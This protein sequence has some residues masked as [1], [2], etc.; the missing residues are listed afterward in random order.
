M[1]ILKANYRHNRS[2]YYRLFTYE[3]SNYVCTYLSEFT[4]EYLWKENDT[5]LFHMQFHFSSQQ[6]L[7]YLKAIE[8]FISTRKTLP[9]PMFYNGRRDF[10]EDSFSLTQ[11]RRPKTWDLITGVIINWVCN[12]SILCRKIQG[13]LS[14]SISNLGV[15][16]SPEGFFSLLHLTTRC[17]CQQVTLEE[18]LMGRK[19]LILFTFILMDITQYL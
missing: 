10:N 5:S 1:S 9:E 17:L 7:L 8:V 15:A 4:M 16:L 19:Q 3:F 14:D 18:L 2:Y 12:S 6:G 11:Q 13:H